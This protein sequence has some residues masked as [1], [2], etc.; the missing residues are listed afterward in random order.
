MHRCSLA[1]VGDPPW[2]P[3]FLGVDWWTPAGELDGA[4]MDELYTF[5]AMR[6]R[7][8]EHVPGRRSVAYIERWFR[9]SLDGLER[10]VAA[11]RSRA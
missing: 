9:A 4:V 3:G 6:V 10:T 7:M 1:F 2:S 8:I 5:M 11:E